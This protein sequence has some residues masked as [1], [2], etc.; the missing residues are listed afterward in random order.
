MSRKVS[1]VYKLLADGLQNFIIN[2]ILVRLWQYIW[3]DIG[4]FYDTNLSL[5]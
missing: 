1:K 4:Y 2:I 3:R 5:T